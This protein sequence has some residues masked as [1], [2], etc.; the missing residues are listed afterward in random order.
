MPKRL[1]YT[2]ISFA[3]LAVAYQCYVLVIC[4]LVEPAPQESQVVVAPDTEPLHRYK[5]LLAAYFP[6]GHWCLE[7]PPKTIDSG[8]SLLLVDRYDPGPE[9]DGQLTI[10]RCAMVLFPTARSDAEPAPRNA[11][12]LEAPGGADLHMEGSFRLG[13][14]DKSSRLQRGVLRG[15]VTVRSGMQRPGPED[16]LWMVTR[17]VYINENL[18]RTESGVKLRLGP[19]R[20]S[21]RVLEAKLA[22]PRQTGLGQIDSVELRGDVVAEV[23]VERL[24]VGDQ[25]PGTDQAAPAVVTSKGPFRLSLSE[26]RATFTGG[27]DVTQAH[28]GNPSDRL[29]C[30]ELSLYLRAEQP[31]ES[32]G[33]LTAGV[34]LEPASLEAVSG[35]GQRVS[36]RAPSQQVSADCERLWIEFGPR[37][38]TL[39]DRDESV[40]VHRQTEVRAPTIRYQAPPKDSGQ[41][42]GTLLAS[43]GGRLKITPDEGGAATP[44]EV[45]WTRS[46]R[47]TRKEGR[48]V[49]SLHGRPRVSLPGTGDLWADS[50]ELLLRERTDQPA[51]QVLPS[52]V[53]PEKLV[54]EGQVA[55]DSAQLNGTVGRLDIDFEYTAKEPTGPVMIGP[56]ADQGDARAERRSYDISGGSLSIRVTV[57]DKKPHISDI[58]LQRRF[59]FRETGA[60][61]AGGQLLE[62][63]G[64]RLSITGANT[65]QA[66]MVL[67]GTPAEVFSEGSSLRAGLIELRR[68]GGRVDIQTPGDLRLLSSRGL[69]GDRLPRPEPLEIHWQRSLSLVGSE[70]TFLGDVRVKGGGGELATDRL[71]A[72]LSRP[73]DFTNGAQASGGVEIERIEAHDGVRG[74]VQRSDATGLT[75]VTTFETVSLSADQKSGEL[76]GSGPGWLETVHLSTGNTPVFSLTPGRRQLEPTPQKLRFLRVEFRRQLAGNLLHPIR[77]QAVGQARA[78]YGPVDSWEQKLP[79]SAAT[80]QRPQTVWIEGD[81]IQV[82]EN[83]IGGTNAS[84]FS[85]GELTVT[86]DV[87]IEGKAS[88]GSLFTA[89]GDRASYDQVKAMFVLE[90]S[91]R[92]SA[93][94]TH[95]EYPGAAFQ[96]QTGTKFTYWLKTGRLKAEVDKLEWTQFDIG[97]QPA[98]AS[99]R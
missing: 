46:L 28:E 71:V 77:V 40:F 31:E 30:F 63:Q 80:D 83:P 11:I 68:G 10:N 21:G 62:L 98:G 53:V 4:P 75:S 52:A 61:L 78:V 22:S 39:E 88:D 66:H 90:G 19:H 85:A 99:P 26:G 79:I 93:V 50:V 67:A 87:A 64:D 43:P 33:G 29:R 73:L 65:E 1:T 47:L 34:R 56:P 59:V 51:D 38:V 13:P 35:G 57:Q 89:R 45:R 74:V 18:I 16:D 17:D 42:V 6:A 23:D 72:K 92:R 54:A 81:R 70:A 15:E 20:A 60:Q 95:Q 44:V 14:R 32:Q 84:G 48:P 5:D 76:A 7:S 3:A 36:L 94:I 24:S 8:D 86:G 91:E 49:L 9:D 37:R 25:Q 41:R 27:V 55:I 58:H 2:A 97:R 96:P 12:I 82:A 69:T